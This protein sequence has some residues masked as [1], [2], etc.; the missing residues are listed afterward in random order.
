MELQHYTGYT[1]PI[2]VCIKYILYLLRFLFVCFKLSKKSG[3]TKGT[4]MDMCEYPIWISYTDTVVNN[5]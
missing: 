5:Y 2:H 3:C 4:Q 1:Y